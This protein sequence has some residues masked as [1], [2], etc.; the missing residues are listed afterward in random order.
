MKRLVSTLAMAG[1]LLAATEASA[2]D[3][4]EI[5]AAVA[6]TSFA[7]VDLSFAIRASVL[8]A[9]E[10][11]AQFGY[12]LAQSIVS[13]PQALAFN[14]AIIGLMGESD[15]PELFAAL[16]VPATMTTALA[17]HGMWSLASP[18]EDQAFMFLASTSLAVNTMWTSFMIGTAASSRDRF[19]DEGAIFGI[20]E[21]VTTAPGIAI[22]IHQ[23]L[24]TNRFQPGWI[25]IASW[26]G[27]N[28]FHGALFTAGV[29]RG[30]D[31]HDYAALPATNLPVTNIGFGP[32]SFGAPIEGGPETPGFVLSGAF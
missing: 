17:I 31:D 1:S 11:D 12:S 30:D 2:G 29:A 20:Y 15:A 8:A 7:A 10:G 3:E 6:I 28:A 24:E 16:H 23:A 25:A 32:T 4:E 22:G 18:D 21:V 27:I 14:G 5:G 26:S 19:D 13:A 9:N